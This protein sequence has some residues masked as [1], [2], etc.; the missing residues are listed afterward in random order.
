M[1]LG[2][3]GWAAEFGI[4]NTLSRRRG[5]WLRGW[6]AFGQKCRLPLKSVHSAQR[7]RLLWTVT[8][9]QPQL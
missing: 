5:Q 4:R 7:R 1:M 3:A 9:T 6:P 8:T 2:G